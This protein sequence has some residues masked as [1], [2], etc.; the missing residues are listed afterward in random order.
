MHTMTP[1]G[2]TWESTPP[3][4]YDNLP[5]PL[6]PYTLYRLQRRHSGGTTPANSSS[7]RKNL[8][9]LYLIFTFQ[10]FLASSHLLLSL[11]LSHSFTLPSTCSSHNLFPF[12]FPVPYAVFVFHFARACQSRLSA[13]CMC[14]LWLLSSPFSCFFYLFPPPFLAP[15]S[16]SSSTPATCF[17][18][19]S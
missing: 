9:L 11:S 13:L 2:V 7:T 19:F 1:Q 12:T 5:P 6:P 4:P 10:L 14:L 3:L 17:M 18:K 15:S 16:T 8:V